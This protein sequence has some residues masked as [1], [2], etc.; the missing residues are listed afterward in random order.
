MYDNQDKTK[1]MP[2]NPSSGMSAHDWDRKERNRVAAWEKKIANARIADWK[3]N[4]R[5]SFPPPFGSALFIPSTPPAWTQQ[6][7][8]SFAML[9][10]PINPYRPTYKPAPLAN[11]TNI[12]RANPE[13]SPPKKKSAVAVSNVSAVDKFIPSNLDF[14]SATGLC[15]E[16][17]SADDDDE[18]KS[19][20]ADEVK[21]TIA[22]EVKSA[23]AD[24]VQSAAAD[25]KCHPPRDYMNFQYTFHK[26]L[27]NNVDQFHCMCHR[28][29]DCKG[30]S[31][32]LKV[33]S[34][35][36]GTE[37][38]E[39]TGTHADGCVARNGRQVAVSDSFTDLR[40]QM[41]QFVEARATHEEHHG[42]TPEQIWAATVKHF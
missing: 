23:A 42:D 9:S 17:T 13:S 37:T 26:S 38:I 18:V 31:A 34:N 39:L 4:M 3:K 22:D 41:K 15:C 21:S 27:A 20:A 12:H 33:C 28:N 7:Q 14:A 1:Y 32:V 5:H 30:C 36:D 24:E 11:I 16:V 8:P 10:F 6:Y 40:V 2:W 35:S 29:K 25:S 19:A